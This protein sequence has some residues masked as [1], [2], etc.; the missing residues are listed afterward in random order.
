MDEGLQHGDDRTLRKSKS[1]SK[2]TDLVAAETDL[3][4]AEQEHEQEHRPCCSLVA[5][6][7]VPEPGTRNPITYTITQRTNS[8]KRDITHLVA[9]EHAHDML[10]RAAKG[11]VDPAHL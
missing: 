1:M 10:A 2:S 5:A 7:T 4:A 6:E 9:A 3:V 11:A 8:N